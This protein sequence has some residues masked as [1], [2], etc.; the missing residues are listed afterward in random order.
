MSLFTENDSRLLEK[1]L[2]IREALVD[3]LIKKEL[4]TNHKDIDS[5]TN[6]LESIDRSILGKAKIK[7]EDSNAK[8]NEETKEILRG[9]L[10]DL[11]RNNTANVS[12]ASA[13][14]SEIPTYKPMN[15]ELNPGELILKQDDV[16]P[17]EV[18]GD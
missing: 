9:L 14:R 8:A 10:L 17:Q 18:L 2:Q 16:S 13:N 3:N 12:T 5:F 6:L 7:V 15:M 4:P 1:T 11:H